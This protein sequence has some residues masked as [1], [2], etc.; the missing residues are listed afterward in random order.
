MQDTKAG[1]RYAKSLF[2]LAQERNEVELVSADMALIDKTIHENPELRSMLKSPIIKSDKKASIIRS[3]FSANIGTT[4]S[5]FLELIIKKRREMYTDA[6]ARQFVILHLEN[7]GIEEALLTTAFKIDD[8][9]R[10]RILDL[11]VKHSKNNKVEL[12]EHIDPSIIGGFVLR[13]GDN[14]IDTSI[15]REIELLRREFDK[16]LYVKEY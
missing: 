4:T 11:V 10:Q 14:Q 7:N 1:I 15:E 5:A 9:F 6:I 3:I 16:N 13:F 12:Q 2:K 8:S